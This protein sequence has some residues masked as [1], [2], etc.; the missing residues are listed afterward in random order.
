MPTTRSLSGLQYLRLRIE[1]ALDKDVFEMLKQVDS[2]YSTS[3]CDAIH[4]LSI[5][6]FTKVE[7]AVKNPLYVKEEDPTWTKDD[8][9]TYAEGLR[10]LLLQKRS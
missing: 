3:H 6:P 1:Y 2:M 5:L 4:K 7:V 9:N 10:E 8:S